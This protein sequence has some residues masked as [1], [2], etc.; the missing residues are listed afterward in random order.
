MNEK[1]HEL[2][3]RA[4]E[5]AKKAHEGQLRKSGEPYF[6]HVFETAKILAR[7]G[8]DARAIAAGLLHDTLEDT[9]SHRA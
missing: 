7:I 3:S 2:V 6:M 8:M 4:Y 9:K 5:F 1:E